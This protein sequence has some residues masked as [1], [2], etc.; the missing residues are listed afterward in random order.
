[1]EISQN[2][3]PGNCLQKIQY[4]YLFSFLFLS[5]T[6]RSSGTNCRVNTVKQVNSEAKQ[7]R[8]EVLHACTL[9]YNTLGAE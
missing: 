8:D 6:W 7:L 5:Y 3:E 1:M 9:V 4:L 2:S